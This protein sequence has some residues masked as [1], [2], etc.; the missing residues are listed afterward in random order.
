MTD[1]AKTSSNISTGMPV[2]ITDS[3]IDPCWIKE[4]MPVFHHI[5]ECTVKDISN[6]TRK[7]DKIKN[8]ATLLLYLTSQDD[9]NNEQ[10]TSTTALV[11]KQVPPSGLALSCQLGL[12]REALFYNKLAP[13]IKV[14]SV[15]NNAVVSDDNVNVSGGKDEPQ[16]KVSCASPCIPKIYY[17]SGDMSDGSKIVIMED[18]S[19]GFIDSGILFGPGNP[20]NWNRDLKSRIAEA[21]PASSSQSPSTVVAVVPPTSFEVANQTFLAIAYVH[22]EFWRDTELLKEEYSWLRGSSWISGKDEKSWRVTQGMIQ[23][24]WA[25]YLDDNDNDDDDNDNDNDNDN[26]ESIQWDPLVRKILEKAMKGISWESHL[27][28]LNVNSHF[29][30]VHGDFWPGNV[31]I[32]KNNTN[33]TSISEDDGVGDLRLL[34]WE[35]VGEYTLSV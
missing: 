6:D 34:D 15:S 32:S 18:L 29:C 5:S 14:R 22:A 17:S 30:L 4:K 9:G 20:N 16:I 8:G 1:C 25:K 27:Q 35:M 28:R 33:A 26:D 2:W 24:M 23:T 7:G 10:T 12:A 3:R 19:G 11:A 13:K 21:Y 31:M